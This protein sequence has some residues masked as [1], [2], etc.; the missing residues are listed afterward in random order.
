[1]SATWPKTEIQEQH[2]SMPGISMLQYCGSIAIGNGLPVPAPDNFEGTLRA[3]LHRGLWV[4][5]CPEEKCSSAVAVTSVD[6]KSFCPD[7]GAGWF[8]V[9]FPKNK[10]AIITELMK[11]PIYRPGLFHANW[12]GQTMV[13]LRAE[14]E[15]IN[16]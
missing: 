15:A 5:L 7:C 16:T 3:Q 8:H 14:T 12:S 9:K 13:D 1:M 4:V 6:P 11:R 2:E 10:A